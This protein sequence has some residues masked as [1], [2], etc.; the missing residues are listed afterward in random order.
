MRAGA[1]RTQQC[2]RRDGDAAD[3]RDVGDDVTKPADSE[4]SRSKARRSSRVTGKDEREAGWP[5]T[6]LEQQ[7]R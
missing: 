5:T 3:T 2:E 4:T 7:R 1:R 6:P